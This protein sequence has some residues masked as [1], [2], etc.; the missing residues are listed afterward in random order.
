M[1][2]PSPGLRPQ[3]EARQDTLPAAGGSSAERL[4][5]VLRHLHSL[6]A[7]DPREFRAAYPAA[8]AEAVSLAERADV[9]VAARAPPLGRLGGALG[10]AAGIGAAE[11]ARASAEPSALHYAAGCGCLE[12]CWAAAGRCPGLLL[13]GDAA[14]GTPLHW[15]AAAGL[16]E[17]TAL[18]LQLRADP[19]ASDRQGRTPMHAAAEGG[20]HRTCG[21]LLSASRGAGSPAAASRMC[22]G[23]TPL[24]LAAARGHSAVAALLLEARADALARTDEGHVALQVA[25][26]AGCLAAAECLLAATEVAAAAQAERRPD[27]GVVASPAAGAVPGGTRRWREQKLRDQWRAEFEPSCRA[28]LNLPASEVFLELGMPR[29]LGADHASLRIVCRVVD[30]LDLVKGYSVEVAWDPDGLSE[31]EFLELDLLGPAV[32]QLRFGKRRGQPPAGD[33]EFVVP[34]RRGRELVWD[35]GRATRFRVLGRLRPAPARE[36][37]LARREV[38]S[39]WTLPLRVPCFGPC[40][41]PPSPGALPPDARMG[42]RRR[43]PARPGLG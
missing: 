24:H 8:A 26:A 42:L 12:A 13:A 3:G 5:E 32:R 33:I 19:A 36:A 29:F 9:R 4:R 39:P 11:Q 41:G 31:S 2:A 21:A 6:S 40:A 1:H 43:A 16:C 10:P 27:E 25:T 30:V 20:F 22:G 37:R 17:T 18:L 14:G 23:L 34:R 15:A 28:L 35:R 38:A 7:R